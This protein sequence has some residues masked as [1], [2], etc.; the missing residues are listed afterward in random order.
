MQTDTEGKRMEA[1]KKIYK[2]HGFELIV[3][4]NK[5]EALRMAMSFIKPQMS[6]GFGG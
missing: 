2:K 5:E 6:I 4:P 3:V 1:L